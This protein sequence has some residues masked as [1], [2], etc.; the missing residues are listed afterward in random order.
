MFD[1]KKNKNKDNHSLCVDMW[2]SPKIEGNLAVGTFEELGNPKHSTTHA[3]RPSWPA[4]SP[5]H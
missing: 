4:S 5:N 2:S 1:E 3:M